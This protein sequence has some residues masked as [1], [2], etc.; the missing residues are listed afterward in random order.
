MS[1]EMALAEC[2]HHSA[3]RQKKARAQEEEREVHFTAAIRRTVPPPEPELFDLHEEPSGARPNL[4]LEPHGPQGRVQRR[5]VVH[6]VDDRCRREGTNW[7]N[8]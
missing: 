5:A 6:I 1:V 7:W 2:Q 4:L 8:S 3:Q